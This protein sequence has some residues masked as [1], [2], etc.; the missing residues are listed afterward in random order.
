MP[1][2]NLFQFMMLISSHTYRLAT[3]SLSL[4]NKI[5]TVNMFAQN[6]QRTGWI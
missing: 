1:R 6:E 3:I 5:F 2:C 4:V